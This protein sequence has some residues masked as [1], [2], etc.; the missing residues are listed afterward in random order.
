[1]IKITP[2]LSFELIGD[3][4][5][6]YSDASEKLNITN[7]EKNNLYFKLSLSC[8]FMWSLSSTILAGLKTYLSVN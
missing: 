5:S 7:V 6:K 3:F 4:H 8:F 2:L 1:M